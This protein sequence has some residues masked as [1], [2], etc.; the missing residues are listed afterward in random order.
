MTFLGCQDEPLV[1]EI[2]SAIMGF[3]IGT[4]LHR[5]IL[6]KMNWCA[7]NLKKCHYPKGSTWQNQ[8]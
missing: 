7:M 6:G 1:D 8:V 3:K 5:E 4:T 2:T